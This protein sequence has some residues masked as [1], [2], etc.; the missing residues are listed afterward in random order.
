MH[1][2]EGQRTVGLASPSYEATSELTRSL[3]VQAHC[4]ASI[5]ATCRLGAARTIQI[6]LGVIPDEIKHSLKAD[7]TWFLPPA[8]SLAEGQFDTVMSIAAIQR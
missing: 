4:G 3:K 5:G 2:K 8:R 1:S 6:A 7:A